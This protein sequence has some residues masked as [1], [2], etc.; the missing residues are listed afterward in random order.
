MGHQASPG[1]VEQPR[2]LPLTLRRQSL[3]GRM[4]FP[5]VG[6]GAIAYMHLIRRHRIVGVEEARRTYRRALSTGRPTLICANHLTMVD[7]A[8]L[9]RAFASV[10]EY[11]RDFRRFAWNV[12]AAEHFMSNAALRTIV[13]LGKC[14]PIARTGDGANAK[15]VLDTIKELVSHGEVVTLFPEGAR[16]RTGRVEPE[17]VTYGIGEILRD[18]DRPQVLCAYLRGEHQ[19]TW[20]NM[21]ARGDTM[22]LRVELLEPVT[23]ERGL[24]AS[25]DLSRQVI[26]RLKDMEEAHFAARNRDA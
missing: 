11:L 8:F 13:Y 2:P 26:N 19:E 4:A 15:Q 14:I 9:H 21:P 18:L 17:N 25:R 12:P 3:A 6:G 24:R 10:G 22:H 16:S 1:E 23:Q 20:S 5:I 7:S